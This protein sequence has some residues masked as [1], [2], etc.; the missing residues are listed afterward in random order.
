M[1]DTQNI[2][3]D[4]K[5]QQEQEQRNEQKKRINPRWFLLSDPD[6]FFNDL[7]MEQNEQQQ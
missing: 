2:N 1:I 3:Q 4:M 6:S 7:L 5:Q